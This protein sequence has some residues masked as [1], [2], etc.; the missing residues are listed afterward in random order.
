MLS[1]E[2]TGPIEVVNGQDATFT[3]NYGNISGQDLENTEL[4]MQYPEGFKFNMSNPQPSRN[5]DVFSLGRVLNNTT[6]KIDIN[7]SFIGD[8]GQEKLVVAEL[9]FV[10]GTSFSPQITSSVAFKVAASSISLIQR[11]TPSEHADFGSKIDYQL[12]YA[13]YGSLTMTNVILTVTVEGAAIDLPQMKAQNAII[14]GNKLTWKA[15]TV[16]ELS[17]VPANGKGSVRFSIPVKQS[18]TTN[19]IN[20]TIKIYATIESDQLKSPIRAQDLELKLSSSIKLQVSGKYVSGSMP[21][22]VGQPTVYSITFMLTNGTNEVSGTELIA[23][24]P[25]P[26][27]A[28]KDVVVPE[29]ERENLIFDRN[30]NKLRWKVG[31]LPA[32]TGRYSPARMV[33]FQLEVVPNIS[34]KGSAMTILKDIQAFGTDTFVNK[35]L[36]TSK[37]SDF[38]TS[39]I[40]EGVS[41]PSVRD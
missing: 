38:R 5:S 26:D 34:D 30:S 20:Q 7:G 12:E 1:L 39:N 6:G 9:G 11:T 27:S 28:W 37:L 31:K 41:D 29:A 3:V 40:E 13:N 23:S 32:L 25:L 18:L 36:E 8:S 19:L 15:A 21:M 17:L 16:P 33:T 24:L 14:T 4:R 10:S 2:I 22:K 35:S